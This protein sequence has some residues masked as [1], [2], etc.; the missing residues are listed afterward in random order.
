MESTGSTSPTLLRSLVRTF[1]ASTA[2]LSLPLISGCGGITGKT[3]ACDGLVYKEF[4]LTRSEYLPCAGA[5]MATL[6]RLAQQIETMLKGDSNARIDASATLGELRIL[7]KKAGGRNLL[8]RWA[9]ESL[10]SL[11]VYIWNAYTQHDACMLVARQL[12]GRAP[13]G[14]EKYRDAARSQCRAYRRSY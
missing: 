13:L 12:F 5:M 6:D 4:G 7:L 2:V 11:N 10:T 14:D 8:E 3:T 9:D 1:I